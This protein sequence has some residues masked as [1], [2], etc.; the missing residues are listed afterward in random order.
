MYQHK[1]NNEKQMFLKYSMR[2][3]YQQHQSALRLEH[4]FFFLT[5][6]RMTVRRE[7]IAGNA[8]ARVQR[9]HEPADLLDITFC[10]R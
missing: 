6:D 8:L 2:T 4:I 10:T 1:Q 5:C 3:C 7:I 9:V